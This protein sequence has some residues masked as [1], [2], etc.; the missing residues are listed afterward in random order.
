MRS[1]AR[2]ARTMNSV[3]QN[4]RGSSIWSRMGRSLSR[5]K[6]LKP[7]SVSSKIDAEGASHEPRVAPAHEVPIEAPH[8]QRVDPAQVATSA[9]FSMARTRLG[10]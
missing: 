1:P 5:R 6:N 8:L 9:P 3:S 4:Q 7:V 10:M 2:S